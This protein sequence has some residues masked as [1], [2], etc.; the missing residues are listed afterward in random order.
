MFLQW[1]LC[2]TSHWGDN[3]PSRWIV[4]KIKDVCLEIKQL[5]GVCF[6]TRFKN[7]IIIA[8]QT[9]SLSASLREDQ[10][11]LHT[12][13]CTNTKV[14]SNRVCLLAGAASSSCALWFAFNLRD[15]G[16][17]SDTYIFIYL[18]SS[19]LHKYSVEQLGKKNNKT[20]RLKKNHSNTILI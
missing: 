16:H 10:C 1:L 13:N 9:F 8:I 4:I 7:T 5:N 18:Q 20:L 17:F 15:C 3:T 6:N 12:L 2:V 19:Y 14:M 11:T